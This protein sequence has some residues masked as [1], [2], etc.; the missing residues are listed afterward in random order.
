MGKSFLLFIKAV[1]KSLL[2]FISYSYEFGKYILKF[3]IMILVA[4]G[5]SEITTMNTFQVGV[6]LMVFWF[7]NL[8]YDTK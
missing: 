7:L 3:Y 1:G 2:E 5:V 8:Y 4:W 6:L